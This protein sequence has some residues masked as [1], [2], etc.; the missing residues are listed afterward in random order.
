MSCQRIKSQALGVKDKKNEADNEGAGGMAQAV[1][2]LLSKHEGLN[3]NPST[4][5]IKR[6]KNRKCRRASI[7][8]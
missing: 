5:H 4:T 7:K 1:E 3:S 8:L 2:C 6:Q